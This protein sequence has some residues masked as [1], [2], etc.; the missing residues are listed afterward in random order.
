MHHHGAAG[1]AAQADAGGGR[2]AQTLRRLEAC[3]HVCRLVGEGGTGVHEGR[4]YLVMELLGASLAQLRAA[5]PGHR[6]EPALV[7]SIGAPVNVAR[8]QAAAPGH[9]FQPVLVRSTG[10]PVCWAPI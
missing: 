8:N 7:Q 9:C 3:G 10:V 5:A 6:F 4:A 1:Q 2:G